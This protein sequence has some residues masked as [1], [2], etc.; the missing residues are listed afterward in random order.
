MS[1]SVRPADT[2]RIARVSCRNGR[3]LLRDGAAT[4]KRGSVST[5]DLFG[6]R[7]SSRQ[8]VAPRMYRLR[9][10]CV[11]LYRHTLTFWWSSEFISGVLVLPTKDFCLLGGRLPSPRVRRARADGR[12]F[13]AGRAR[14]FDRAIG[15][16]ILLNRR[17]ATTGH[18]AG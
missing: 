16:K 6:A 10:R 14:R 12:T 17:V 5:Q 7:L 13:S 1:E 2:G 9:Q 15:G 11:G 3:Y 8:A 18:C 4:T